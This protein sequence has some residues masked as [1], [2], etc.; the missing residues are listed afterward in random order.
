MLRF[1]IIL[2]FCSL[3][4]DSFSQKSLKELLPQTGSTINTFVPKGWLKIY[5]TYGDFDKDGWKDAAI[6]MIDSIYEKITMEGNRSLV[7]LKGTKKG[8]TLS[9]FCDSAFLCNNCGGVHGDPFESVKF[10]DNILTLSHYGGSGR[11]WRY[12][13]KFQY[14]NGEWLLIG[15]TVYNWWL[16]INDEWKSNDKATYIEDINFLTGDFVEKEIN[17][18]GII[19]KNKK[20]R[21]KVNPLVKLRDFNITD[22]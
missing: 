14:R 9:D 21:K 20:G 16:M 6:V 18:S 13:H 15:R 19:V 3:R 1:C 2:F 4:F 22:N 7:I 17:D 5:T 12:E 11:R 8:F 10:K